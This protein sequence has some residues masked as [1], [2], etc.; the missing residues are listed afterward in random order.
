MTI[1]KFTLSIQ[2]YQEVQMPA[3]ARILSCQVQDGCPQLWAIV[4]PRKAMKTR[5]IAVRGAGHDFAPLHEGVFISTV[6]QVG[7]QLVWHVFDLGWVK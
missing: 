4:D 3:G 6:Q 1:W 2:G 5:T 7:E